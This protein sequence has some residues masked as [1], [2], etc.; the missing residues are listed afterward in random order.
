MERTKFNG[1][2]VLIRIK[3]SKVRQ[4]RIY[5]F[6]GP[7]IGNGYVG[8]ETNDP[9]D[10]KWRPNY[11]GSSNYLKEQIKKFGRK[12]YTKKILGTFTFIDRFEKDQR[13]GYYI[14]KYQTL[15]PNGLNFYDPSKRPG[16]NNTGIHLSEERL[17]IE[18]TGKIFFKPQIKTLEEEKIYHQNCSNG[19]KKRFENPIERK[20]ARERNIG[21][22]RTKESNEKTR[23]SLLVYYQTDEGKE[24]MK[25]R[26][27]SRIGTHYKLK[28][29]SLWIEQ[30][31]ATHPEANS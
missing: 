11:N 6:T 10:F 8:S 23:K 20:K 15:N 26:N 21:R 9:K 17:G 5:L 2:Q 16:Y 13:E 27:K 25:N 14:N 7:E 30:F 19:Q 12:V 4:Y 22:I 29:L 28:K 24:L 18:K 1:E 3:H 31:Y